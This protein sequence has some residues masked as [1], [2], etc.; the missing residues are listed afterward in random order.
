MG[1]PAIRMTGLRKSFGTL[2]AV[3]GID[4]QIAD[5]EFFAMLGPSSCSPCCRSGWRSGSPARQRAPAAPEV[6]CSRLCS[7]VSSE[8]VRN[9]PPTPSAPSTPSEICCSWSSW[10]S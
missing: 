9:V 7:W 8:A 10:R 2:E 4:L 6:A 3:A 1:A 5:G